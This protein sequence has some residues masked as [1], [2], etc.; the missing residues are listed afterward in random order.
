MKMRRLT[1]PCSVS[2][3]CWTSVAIAHLLRIPQ[4]FLPRSPRGPPR[5][6]PPACTANAGDVRVRAD[7]AGTRRHGAPRSRFPGPLPMHLRLAM[8]LEDLQQPLAHQEPRLVRGHVALD[9]V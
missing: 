2:T 7:V 8:R 9:A 1:S 3:N 6:P 5:L 4:A